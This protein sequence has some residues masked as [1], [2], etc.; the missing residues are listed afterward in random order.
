MSA[1]V[2]NLT[3]PHTWTAETL[4][5]R[6]LILPARQY[7]YP[8]R[9]EEVER[10]ALEMLIHPT[11]ADPF[12]ATFA[13]GFSDPSAPSG[14]WSCPSPDWLCAVAGGY[15]YLV[16]TV[17]PTQFEQI[18]YRPVLKVLALPERGLLIFAGH[19]SL[20]A[21]GEQGKAWQT[22]RLSWEGVQVKRVEGN[23]LEGIGWDMLSDSDVTF[24]I[25]LRTGTRI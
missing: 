8:R 7:V 1:P 5:G 11:A 18:E 21:W 10:G 20:L 2:V 9:A 24:K 25:D 3:F 15:A 22:D 19:H 14:L 16:N 12:L 4:P 6:P 17:D 23:L 13:L